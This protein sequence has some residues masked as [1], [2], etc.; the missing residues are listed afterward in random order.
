MHHERRLPRIALTPGE[1][2]GIGPDLVAGLADFDG[3]AEIVVIGDRTVLDERAKQLGR[4]MALSPYDPGWRTSLGAGRLWI[5][6][7][8]APRPVVPGILD[9]GNARY[10]LQTLERAADGCLRGEF[11]ALVTGPVQKSVINAAGFPFTGHTEFLAERAG[12]RVPVMMLVAGVLRIALATTHLP[13]RRVPDALTTAGLCY[14]IQTVAHAL[15]SSF[16]I[17]SPRLAVCGLNPHAGEGGYLGREEIE[18]IV[19]AIEA[20]RANGLQIDGP[21][22]G[23][24]AF[25]P[26]T[27]TQ[28]AGYVS[29]FHDQGLPVLKALGFGHAVNVTLGLP[30]IRT[31][32]DH[33]TALELAGTGRGE[34]G[35][36]RAALALA[37]SLH[38]GRT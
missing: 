30:F 11:D 16:G 36:L 20:C 26:R 9:A 19:P 37:L 27:R 6:H 4:P 24:T 31:S 22:P 25:T 8:E 2:A 13:L 5:E 1:P 15:E 38:H 35:S 32:V 18:I 10:V 34:L 12:G 14:T 28:Y 3:I 23:D 33:G 21:L 29:M 17:R 7:I